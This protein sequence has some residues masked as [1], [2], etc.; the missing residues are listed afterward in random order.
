MAE[1]KKQGEQ[2]SN[3]WGMLCTILGMVIGTGVIWRFPREVAANNGGA[4][5]ILTF[6]ATFIWAV[7]LICA[8][9]VFGKKTRMAN[10]GGFKAILGP[11]YAWLGLVIATVCTLIGCYY[12]SVFGWVMKYLYLILTGFLSDVRAGGITFAQDYF[13]AFAAT[14]P[15]YEA[16]C[17]FMLA[18]VVTALIIFR[19]IQGGIEKANNI[20]IPS[21]FLF[22]AI[23]LV[24]VLMIPGA[25]KGLVYMFDVNAADFLS[26]KI[27]LAAFTQAAWT[28]G[29]GWGM[30]HVYFVYSAKDEDIELNTLT[31]TSGNLVACLL[32]GMVVLCAVY[33]LA[34]DP[35]LVMKA[36]SNGLTFVH[37]TNL[38][39][40]TSGGFLLAIL[41]FLALFAAALSTVLGLFE[42][43]VRNLIDMGFSRTKATLCISVFFFVVGSFSALDMRIFDNQDFTWGVGLL[44]AGLIYSLAAIKCGA[45]KM[46]EE[47]IAPCSNVRIKWLWMAV[48]FIPLEFA[49]IWGW[50][51]W[52]A[53]SWYPGEWY[54]FWP[55]LKYQFTPGTMLFE[56]VVVTLICIAFNS[57]V[58]K[59]LVHSNTI[60]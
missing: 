29:A 16:W 58:A 36:G 31:V 34:P 17:W 18:I 44:A 51:V 47:D 23:L 20:L 7:P 19:G 6:I 5:I 39:A 60:E 12:V 33:A 30:F 42:I 14:P 26:P 53:A 21:I 59:R 50:W 48:K 45:E 11:K 54:K 24:R 28:T 57:V 38:F 8:E 49:F 43:G 25:W 10:A 1:I 56:W 40:N 4:F 35:D 15:S 52:Q 37:L 2:F 27:W 13:N 32:A 55:I 41:F 46:W 9:S 22:L 3:R